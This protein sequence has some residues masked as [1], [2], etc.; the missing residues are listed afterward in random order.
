MADYTPVWTALNST[1]VLLLVDA[2]QNAPKSGYD[3]DL[4]EQ[5]VQ[6]I[7]LWFESVVQ[8]RAGFTDFRMKNGAWLCVRPLVPA[9]ALPQRPNLKVMVLR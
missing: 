7:F 1:H 4:F 9:P 5:K 3:I 2:R 8:T 6:E